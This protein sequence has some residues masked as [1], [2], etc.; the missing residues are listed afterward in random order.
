MTE[1]EAYLILQHRIGRG[2]HATDIE[3]ALEVAKSA[4]KK[5]YESQEE[6]RRPIY[7][8]ATGQYTSAVWI[9][10]NIQGT[11]FWTATLSKIPDLKPFRYFSFVHVKGKRVEFFYNDGVLVQNGYSTLDFWIKQGD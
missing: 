6:I 11:D 9:L 3:E 7:V 8:E 5:T 10:S 1:R 2:E 4:L